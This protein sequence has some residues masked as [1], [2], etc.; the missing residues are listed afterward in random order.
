LRT[1]T[2]LAR[3]PFLKAGFLHLREFLDFVIIHIQRIEDLFLV[4]ILVG[5][6]FV[7]LKIPGQAGDDCCVIAGMTVASLPA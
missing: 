6:G 3:H 1:P 2:D 7:C 5:H 4:C